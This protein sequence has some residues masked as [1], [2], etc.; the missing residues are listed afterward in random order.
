MGFINTNISL[1]TVLFLFC[2]PK[3]GKN[4]SLRASLWVCKKGDPVSLRDPMLPPAIPS[5]P[6]L[7]KVAYAL[8]GS[9]CALRLMD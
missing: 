7:G 9:C 5:R 4:E 2:L 6:S 3:K 1:P 8:T